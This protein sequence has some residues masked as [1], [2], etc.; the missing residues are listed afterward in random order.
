MVSLPKTSK[1]LSSYFKYLLGI[2]KPLRFC[3]T[4]LLEISIAKQ[5]TLYLEYGGREDY[6]FNGGREQSVSASKK[7]SK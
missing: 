6:F 4:F 7:G 3:D 5:E 1:K 2:A